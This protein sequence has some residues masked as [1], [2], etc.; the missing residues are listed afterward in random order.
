M[1]TAP[2]RYWDVV[3]S[4]PALPWCAGGTSWPPIVN[5]DV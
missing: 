2:G 1:V 3:S 5:I 4:A